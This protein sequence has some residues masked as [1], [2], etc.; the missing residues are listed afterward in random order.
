M[1]YHFGVRKIEYSGRRKKFTGRLALQ[2]LVRNNLVRT[3][4][5]ESSIYDRY[6]QGC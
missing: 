2:F 1:L 3:R 5:L 6:L 4:R